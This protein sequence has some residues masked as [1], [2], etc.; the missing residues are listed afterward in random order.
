MKNNLFNDINQSWLGWFSSSCGIITVLLSLMFNIFMLKSVGFTS[1]AIT[2]LA[3]V[4]GF[5]M[6]SALI[7]VS[8]YLISMNKKRLKEKIDNPPGLTWT[9]YNQN[10][11]EIGEIDEANY[12]KA[13]Y[14][15]YT[16]P[17]VFLKQLLNLFFIPF[18]LFSKLLLKLPSLLVLGLTMIILFIPEINWE[19]VTFGNMVLLVQQNA[20]P[21]LN[22]F[23]IVAVMV[24]GI[25]FLFGKPL[26]GYKNQFRGEL[27]K[28]LAADLPLLAVV[29]GFTIIGHRI[30]CDNDVEIATK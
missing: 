22:I 6:A 25:S 24:I 11:I 3:T 30:D 18:C 13:R 4:T 27:Q 23:S 19:S 12:Y 16:S 17:A 14:V 29:D 28:H 21:L 26:P 10:H 9:V 5:Y 15:V 7:V 2:M 1:V 20:W 8:D